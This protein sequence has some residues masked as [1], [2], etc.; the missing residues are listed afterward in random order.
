MPW[1]ALFSSFETNK[2]V[3]RLAKR[4]FDVLEAANRTR[5]ARQGGYARPFGPSWCDWQPCTSAAGRGEISRCSSQ[6]RH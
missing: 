5:G 6:S 1:T 4:S 2:V 3:R